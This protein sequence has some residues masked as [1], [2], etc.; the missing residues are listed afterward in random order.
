[1]PQAMVLTIRA[2]AGRAEPQLVRVLQE[3]ETLTLANYLQWFSQETATAWWDDSADPEEMCRV[4]ANGA[5]GVTTNP[6]LS[7]YRNVHYYATR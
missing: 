7:H 2:S 4:L 1:M 3:G 5:V 6:V